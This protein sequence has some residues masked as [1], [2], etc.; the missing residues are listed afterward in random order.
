MDTMKYKY[1]R[2][3]IPVVADMKPNQHNP[4]NKFGWVSYGITPEEY[5]E[6]FGLLYENEG[7]KKELRRFALNFTTR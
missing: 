3:L 5:P 4:T 2:I 6:L 1:D 7:A